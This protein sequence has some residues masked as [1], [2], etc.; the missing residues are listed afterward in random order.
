MQLEYM[1]S[2]S[3][4]VAIACSL[5]ECKTSLLSLKQVS[6]HDFQPLW[7]VGT[8][9]YWRPTRYRWES[10]VIYMSIENTRECK[11]F[12]CV[13][14]EIR[15]SQ[16]LS[17][18]LVDINKMEIM[19]N[20]IGNFYMHWAIRKIVVSNV[21]VSRYHCTYFF[22]FIFV[23]FHYTVYMYIFFQP[24]DNPIHFYTSLFHSTILGF[25]R[26]FYI[27]MITW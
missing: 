11:T 22:C 9:I 21:E 5:H 23:D 17:L 25:I 24:L 8:Y 20:I 1:R 3:A 6:R 13:P 14:L 7:Q 10:D 12:Y 27:A 16:R 4:N 26:E 15:I 18:E 2:Q 19:E